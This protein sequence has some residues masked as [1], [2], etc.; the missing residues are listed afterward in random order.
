[1]GLRGGIVSEAD[2][3]TFHILRLERRCDRNEKR[4]RN[5]A[6]ER[7]R[8]LVHHLMSLGSKLKNTGRMSSVNPLGNGPN[9]PACPA[10]STDPRASWSNRKSPERFTRRR[11]ATDPSRLILKKTS[12]V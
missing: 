11:A 7:E 6:D 12:A 1:P 4:C 9:D 2:A 10:A 8:T 5:Q 3:H